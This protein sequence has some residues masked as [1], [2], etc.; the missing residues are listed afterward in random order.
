[1]YFVLYGDSKIGTERAAMERYKS[2]EKEVG[3]SLPSC[4]STEPS[5]LAAVHFCALN[6]SCVRYTGQA[7]NVVYPP[8]FKN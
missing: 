6:C 1:M 4:T 2:K 8:S 3:S 7:F 5:P